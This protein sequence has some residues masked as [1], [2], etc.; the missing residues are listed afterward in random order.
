MAYYPTLHDIAQTN[1]NRDRYATSPS[2]SS[3]TPLRCT[4]RLAQTSS[5]SLFVGRRYPK[6]RSSFCSSRCE[7]RY[8]EWEHLTTH[9]VA[10]REPLQT[11]FEQGRVI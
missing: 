11:F 1:P 2:S 4:T 8:G 9:V 5:P 3:N 7:E 10:G 6:P